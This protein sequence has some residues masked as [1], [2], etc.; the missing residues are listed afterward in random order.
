M[1]MGPGSGS[2]LNFETSVEQGHLV[3][4]GARQVTFEYPRLVGF[5]ETDFDDPT[6]SI[7]GELLDIAEEPSLQILRGVQKATEL[8]RAGFSVDCGAFAALVAGCE[9]HDTVGPFP[10]IDDMK[11]QA[12]A[13][14]GLPGDLSFDDLMQPMKVAVYFTTNA[15]GKPRIR[16]FAVRLPGSGSPLPLVLSKFGHKGG[17]GITDVLLPSWLY[18]AKKVSAVRRL[19]ISTEGRPLI[20]Y[21]ND[22]GATG[23]AV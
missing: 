20:T 11:W 2:G 3:K 19:L 13:H 10:E 18:Q 12:E 4:G 23:A 7:D 9:V 5:P 22:F 17:V 21:E 8:V 1:S 14:D 16:H 15:S 6:I